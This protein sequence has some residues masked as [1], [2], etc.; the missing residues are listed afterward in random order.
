MAYDICK[1]CGRFFEKDGNNYCTS[2]R[3]TDRKEYQLLREFVKKNPQVKVYEASNMTG[4]P[5]KTI[6]RFVQERRIHIE[7]NGIEE[8]KIS[9]RE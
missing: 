3:E 4:L 1:I 8:G 6:M 5:V 9:F 2:C 7:N